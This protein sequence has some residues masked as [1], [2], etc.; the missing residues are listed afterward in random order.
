ME[1]TSINSAEEAEQPPWAEILGETPLRW[2]V[3]FSDFA[4]P[5]WFTRFMKPGTAHVFTLGYLPISNRWLVVQHCFNT[6]EICLL[7][8]Q[9]V[10]DFTI[11]M[12]EFNTTYVNCLPVRKQQLVLRGNMNCVSVTKHLLGMKAPFVWTGAQLKAHL[13]NGGAK[14]LGDWN[15]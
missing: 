9:R 11:M 2:V 4:K 3:G 6:L 1:Q 13:I 10:L 5:R 8:P 14:D 15:G 7:T 12:E